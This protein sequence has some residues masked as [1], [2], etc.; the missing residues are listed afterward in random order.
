MWAWARR[1]SGRRS[2]RSPEGGG[3]E[4]DPRRRPRPTTASGPWTRWLP[5]RLLDDELADHP[6]LFV[7]G[8]RAVE[9]VGPGREAGGEGRDAV[10]DD[11]SLALAVDRDVVLDTG[12][13]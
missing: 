9:R 5:K 2:S 6:G 13:V 8:N 4:A 11:L 7:A 10:G 1:G 12:L 3:V